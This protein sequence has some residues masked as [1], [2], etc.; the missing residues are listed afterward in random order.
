MRHQ[1]DYILRGNYESMTC[2][3]LPAQANAMKHFRRSPLAQKAESVTWMVGRSEDYLT[4]PSTTSETATDNSGRQ[5]ASQTMAQK[6]NVPFTRRESSNLREGVTRLIQSAL[7]SLPNLHAMTFIFSGPHDMTTSP[8]R[9]LP[10]LSDEPL[11]RMLDLI[12]VVAKL[13]EGRLTLLG[14][15]HRCYYW[16]YTVPVLGEKSIEVSY[17]GGP[18]RFDSHSDNVFFEETFSFAQSLSFCQDLGYHLERLELETVSVGLYQLE[19]LAKRTRALQ[20]LWLK[21]CCIHVPREEFD[22]QVP[23]ADYDGPFNP[24]D[25]RLLAQLR[26]LVVLQCHGSA[27]AMRDLTRVFRPLSR[28]GCLESL[29]FEVRGLVFDWTNDGVL[30][31]GSKLPAVI[32]KLG[33]SGA[34]KRMDEC[35]KLSVEPA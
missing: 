12:R 6:R 31:D 8:P 15:W 20:K 24:A 9:I 33:I 35:W 5:R 29:Y 3:L 30:D 27:V 4:R 13:A 10:G 1:L 32:E 26:Q 14:V 22:I 19:F 23:L 2:P 18:G 11:D 34:L 21:D 25:S 7:A 28:H 17:Y 16:V